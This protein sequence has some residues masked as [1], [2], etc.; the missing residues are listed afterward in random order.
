MN[1]LCH[2]PGFRHDAKLIEETGTFYKVCSVRPSERLPSFVLP[3]F[4]SWTL[5]SVLYRP[6]L[7]PFR[8]ILLLIYFYV[9]LHCLPL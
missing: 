9:V 5:I 8:E 3:E 4:H 7:H 6:N 1:E 2:L